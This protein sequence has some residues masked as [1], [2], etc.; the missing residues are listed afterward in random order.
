VAAREACARLAY[1]DGLT[2]TLKAYCAK[3]WTAKAKATRAAATPELLNSGAKAKRASCFAPPVPESRSLH[4]TAS[5]SSAYQPDA[6]EIVP[7]SASRDAFGSLNNEQSIKEQPGF[8]TFAS[9]P[10]PHST[11]VSTTSSPAGSMVAPVTPGSQPPQ[12]GESGTSAVPQRVDEA[13]VLTIAPAR[14]S[15]PP[16]RSSVL[17]LEGGYLVRKSLAFGSQD[18]PLLDFC[19]T[20]SMPLPAYQ[21]QAMVKDGKPAQRIWIIIGDLKFELDKEAFANDREGRERLAGRVLKHLVKEKNK[22]RGA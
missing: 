12:V 6:P 14:E 22:A 18:E 13:A 17:Q 8:T 2:D 7:P 19:R 15:G 5:T 16:T 20:N 9:N 1:D 4:P 3:I 10:A 21:S 11:V